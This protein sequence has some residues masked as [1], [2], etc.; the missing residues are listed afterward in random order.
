MDRKK[1]NIIIFV[2]LALIVLV[3]GFQVIKK[4]NQLDFE[5]IDL[6]TYLGL[7]YNS[8]SMEDKNQLEEKIS[9]YNEFDL[10][11]KNQKDH[12]VLKEEIDN[13]IKEKGIK[14][15]YQGLLELLVDNELKFK[16][17]GFNEISSLEEERDKLLKE[18]DRLL[19]KKALKTYL[20]GEKRLEDIDYEIGRILLA[21]EIDPYEVLEQ[22]KANK[23]Q[24]A[25]VDLED[26]EIKDKSSLNPDEDYLFSSILNEIKRIYPKAY[27]NKISKIEINTDGQDG[28]I[29][30]VLIDNRNNEN[31]KMA[32][33][34][35]DVFKVNGN[36]VDNF[37]EI[38]MEKFAYIL[39]LDKSQ[40]LNYYDEFNET[41]G[42]DGIS[43]KEDSYLNLYYE[44]FWK[45][46]DGAESSNLPMDE[47]GQIFRDFI[48]EERPIGKDDPSRKVLFLYDYQ[49]LIDLRGEI[50]K[51][52]GL[53]QGE[54]D[55]G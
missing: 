8:L 40:R 11:K 16:E 15:P 39:F 4:K 12:Q 5:K 47:L 31:W 25:L 20:E 32:F 22:L 53:D 3:V 51:N 2:G 48:L 34:K 44:R 55:L 18:R 9:E 46:K 1:Q 19:K 17:E 29:V 10:S 42:I 7:D 21:N 30:E 49:E 28:N 26:G 41:Y 35:R 45:D 6:K 54:E 13:L 50:R 27:V 36:L 52:L 14:M 38:L 33:D 24:L 37:E 43:L 23:V